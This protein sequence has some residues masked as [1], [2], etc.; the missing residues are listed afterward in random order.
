VRLVAAGREDRAYASVLA[1]YAAAQFRRGRR[2]GVR[3][4]KRDVT[5]S[6]S[7][8]H[9]GAVVERLDRFDQESGGWR[10][11][12]VED[13]RCGPDEVAATRI[14]FNVWLASLPKRNRHIAEKLAVGE[15]TNCVARFFGI[16]PGRVSQ[17]RRE[18]HRAWHAFQ[19]EPVAAEL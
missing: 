14:D 18:L 12:L 2:V 11:I 16:T 6:Y 10:E 4:N 9:T 19:G 17:L 5:S 13:R 15:S 7:Q 1:G 3:A 8:R